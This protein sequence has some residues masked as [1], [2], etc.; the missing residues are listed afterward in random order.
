M[1]A[2]A[3]ALRSL[4]ATRG[5]ALALPLFLTRL[6]YGKKS[7]PTE[8]FAFEEMPKGSV[9]GE[10]AWASSSLLVA[11]AIA[12]GFEKLG[13][14]L[15]LSG[16]IDLDGLPMHVYKDDGESVV[17]PCA[18]VLLVE[19]AADRITELGFVPIQ[20]FKGGDTVRVRGIISVAKPTRPL[21]GR[22]SK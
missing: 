7:N 16:A 1:A 14:E 21:I 22:W 10:Y 15:K 11:A 17:K 8:H 3:S 5:L 6:P 12:R 9:H 13:W 18:E 19:R 4:R 2:V 20:S